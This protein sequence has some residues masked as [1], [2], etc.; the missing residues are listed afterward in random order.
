MA[1]NYLSN[2]EADAPDVRDVAHSVLDAIGDLATP[3]LLVFKLRRLAGGVGDT[4]PGSDPL[5]T[6]RPA[7]RE[8]WNAELQDSDTVRVAE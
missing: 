6:S 4:P 3:T 1:G 2:P 7:A 8:S 5:A